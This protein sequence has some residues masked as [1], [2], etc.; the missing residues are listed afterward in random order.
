MMNDSDAVRQVEGGFEWEVQNIG[1]HDMDIFQVAGVGEGSVHCI[2]QIDAHNSA[3]S[4]LSRQEDVTTLATA[5]VQDD[6]IVE[7]C[8][9]QR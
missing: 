8:R 5:G 2:R 4:E 6:F 9:R 3:R 1:L 7:V